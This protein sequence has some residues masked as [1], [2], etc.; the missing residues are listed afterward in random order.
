M[1]KVFLKILTCLLF[2]ATLISCS[3]DSDGVTQE[4][5]SNKL[6]NNSINKKTGSIWEGIIG[7]ERDGEYVITADQDALM[8]YFEYL[9][10]EEGDIV[11]LEEIKIEK[12]TA[13]NDPNNTAYMLIASAGKSGGGLPEAVNIAVILVKG[14][15]GFY[16]GAGLEVGDPI[17]VTSCRGCSYGCNLRYY[18]IG[19]HQVPYCDENGCSRYNC[20][21]RERPL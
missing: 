8:S 10:K 12:Q 7:I 21:K 18:T 16:L 3:S 9:M 6:T 14:P 4:Q 5:S 19:K 1:K 2:L 11:E 13:T 17:I 15:N 20:T